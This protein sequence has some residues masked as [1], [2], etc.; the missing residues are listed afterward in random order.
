MEQS[1]E[2]NPDAIELRT[3][4]ETAMARADVERRSTPNPVTGGVDK[5]TEVLDLPTAEGQLM[6]GRTYGDYPG[7]TILHVRVPGAIGPNAA[8]D[9]NGNAAGYL[10]VRLRGDGTP[11]AFN[12]LSSDAT[13]G[14]SILDADRLKASVSLALSA[15]GRALEAN[16]APVPRKN[17]LAA[18]LGKLL[19]FRKKL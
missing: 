19:H 16:P 9:S 15:L 3:T 2:F 18:A 1:A 5:M 7:E 6:V 4:I 11:E 14:Q 10:D 13:D 8:M 12:F 17:R